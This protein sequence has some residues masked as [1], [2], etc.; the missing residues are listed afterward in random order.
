[1]SVSITIDSGDHIAAV[2]SRTSTGSGLTWIDIEIPEQNVS[3]QLPDYGHA[4]A[5]IAQ[6]LI[7]ELTEA[8]RK[9]DA[10][11]SAASREREAEEILLGRVAV[12]DD[13]IPF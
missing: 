9:I 7:D 5:R 3:I 1:M 8:I 10:E 4:C 13:D 2:V 6:K 11:E 12:S